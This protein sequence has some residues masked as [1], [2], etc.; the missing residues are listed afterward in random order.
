M[1]NSLYSLFGYKFMFWLGFILSFIYGLC[2]GSF[3]NVVIF[4]LPIHESLS[5]E[6][7]HC[8]KCGNKIKWYDNIP[9]FSYIILRGKCRKCGDR[10]SLQYPI[11]ELLNAI[12]WVL[13]YFK[14]GYSVETLVYII[15]SSVLVCIAFIDEKTFEIPAILNG[16]I[17]VIGIIYTVYDYKHWLT[18]IIGMLCVSFVLFLIWFFTD[19]IGFG[20]VKLMFCSGLLLGWHIIIPSFLI[21]CI[22][23]IIIHSI[24]MK[25]SNKGHKLA[26]GP[27]LSLG[28]YVGLFVG[29]PLMTMYLRLIG[30]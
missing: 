17:L 3:L 26:F 6:A 4:R 20:D 10:I 1:I 21:G 18:H 25:V 2:I 14:Y 7:S 15:L 9:L 19:G 22:I 12:L 5:K 24:R 23:A 8:F 28:I 13:I 11:V 16:W 29:Q 30:V 27:Y